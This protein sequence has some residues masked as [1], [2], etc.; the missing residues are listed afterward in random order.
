MSF[1]RSLVDFPD[2]LIYVSPTGFSQI[3]AHEESLTSAQDRKTITDNDHD[4]AIR[5]LT[6][7]QEELNKMKV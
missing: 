2:T 6:Q 4:G 5:E 3:K 7:K 1:S